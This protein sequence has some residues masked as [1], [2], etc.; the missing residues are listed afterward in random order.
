MLLVA[1]LDVVLAFLT[2]WLAIDIVGHVGLSH[3]SCQIA[4]HCQLR[5]SCR[6]I[7]GVILPECWLKFC[8]SVESHSK[9]T[10][11]VKMKIQ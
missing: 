2:L 5:P 9:K 4:S 10:Y 11:S 7:N 1:N 6:K 3:L 8:P